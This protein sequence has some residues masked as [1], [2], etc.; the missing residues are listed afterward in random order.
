MARLGQDQGGFLFIARRH[1]QLLASLG[2]VGQRQHAR[3]ASHLAVEAEL[4][5]HDVV[6][7]LVVGQIGQV[8]R[9]LEHDDGQRQIE[10][11]AVLRH[12]GRRHP[13]PCR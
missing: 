6:A 13:K 2:H 1:D 12:V 9:G 3:H 11:R 5:N 4:T 8:A 7:F 10:P